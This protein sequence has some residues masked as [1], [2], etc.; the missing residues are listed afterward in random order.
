MDLGL[1]HQVAM[2]AFQRWKKKA[3][4]GPSSSSWG[5]GWR[6][7]CRT[8]FKMTKD[9]ETVFNVAYR[10]AT[11]EKVSKR[12]RSE[13]LQKKEEYCVGEVLV[14]RTYF[15]IRKQVFNVNYEYKITALGNSSA[16]TLMA[17]GSKPPPAL[18]GRI[19]AGA[20]ARCDRPEQANA[21]ALRIL[22]LISTGLC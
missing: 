1:N 13:L 11:C 17:Q 18:A 15:K 21:S 19:C 14:C 12:V 9:L 6:A 20:G 10:N 2:A 5:S 4:R 8:Y 16:I 22:R 3:S 7:S